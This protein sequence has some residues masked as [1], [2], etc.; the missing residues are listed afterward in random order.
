MSSM[1]TFVSENWKW[2]GTV[3]IGA[4]VLYSQFQTM[5]GAQDTMQRR[6]QNYIE[7]IKEQDKTIHELEK[8]VVVLETT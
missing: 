7:V 1:S 6:L 4:G 3:L 2:V 5:K 8:R